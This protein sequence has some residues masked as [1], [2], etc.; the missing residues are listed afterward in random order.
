MM[1]QSIE[2]Q[3]FS[4][5][6]K[7]D[8][9]WGKHGQLKSLEHV[10][11]KVRSN[12]AVGVAEAPAR[13]SIYGE[14]PQ[15]IKT[16]ISDYLAP[17]LIGLELN[18]SDAISDVLQSVENNHTAKGA[19]DI[20]IHD[21][22]EKRSGTSLFEQC[23]GPNKS[24][25]VSF[26]LGISSFETMLT[27]ARNIFEAGV[28]VFKI[29]VGRNE[30][31][32]QKVIQALQNEFQGEDVILYADANEG[33]EAS[34]AAK[35]LET[36]A[37]LGIAYI[38]EPLAVRNLKARAA[39]KREQIMPIIADD[40]CFSLKDLEREIDFDT[41]DILNIKTARTGFSESNAM[42]ELALQHTKGVMIGSQA[43]AGLGTL[44]AALFASQAGID[45]PSELS[46]PL[47]LKRDILTQPIR[48]KQGYLDLESLRKL[49]LSDSL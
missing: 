40:S 22:K 33:L 34:T 18:D 49:E 35:Q 31:H 42:L 13:P 17:K 20:A 1:I 19:L 5:A 8:L 29:K 28:S 23:L 30:T 12:G 37:K 27:E 15:S 47:K 48:Y 24:L 46:F 4:L 36:L 26:I 2:T 41:F 32:D 10:L 39:L 25:R 44:H 11:V 14:T 38:E 6:M 3:A 21:L 16:I 45:Y 43:S 7:G 9:S